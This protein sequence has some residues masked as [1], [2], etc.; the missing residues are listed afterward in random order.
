M[1]LNNIKQRKKSLQKTATL[2]NW[3]T[4]C[5]RQIDEDDFLLNFG[6]TN[7]ICYTFFSYSRAR[8]VRTGE[9]TILSI[10][11]DREWRA[12]SSGTQQGFR[13]KSYSCGGWSL[14][15][16]ATPLFRF[17]AHTTFRGAD[18]APG[19]YSFTTQLNMQHCETINF[20][21]AVAATLCMSSLYMYSE[22]HIVPPVGYKKTR[23]S[24][25]ESSP[26]FIYYPS[27]SIYV[28][29]RGFRKRTSE[30]ISSSLFTLLSW[31]LGSMVRRE[32]G[33]SVEWMR[34]KI[35][36]VDIVSDQFIL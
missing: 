2:H 34:L 3:S 10:L 30:I 6:L 32:G 23:C 21:E 31:W 36:K 13:N 19:L 27:S 24:Y 12:L 11:I 1:L 15:K 7:E 33:L 35:G 8:R 18:W 28:V 5:K 20:A 25:I 14:L 9:Y 17:P 16:R 4:F 22:C 26:W 29:V